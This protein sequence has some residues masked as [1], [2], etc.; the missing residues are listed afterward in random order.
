MQGMSR[1]SP[2]NPKVFQDNSINCDVCDVVSLSLC[3][4][5]DEQKIPD[6]NDSWICGDCQLTL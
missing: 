1:G 6:E 2:Y 5:S 4:Y 3:K